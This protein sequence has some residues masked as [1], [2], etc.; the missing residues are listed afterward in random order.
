M[1]NFFSLSVKK[2]TETVREW[3]QKTPLKKQTPVIKILSEKVYK[4]RSA[5]KGFVPPKVF[6]PLLG[7]G[8]VT[9][10]VQTVHEV[11]DKNKNRLGFALRLRD[12]NEVGDAFIGLYHSTCSTFRL[13][14][15]PETA[16]N[17]NDTEATGNR[18][19]LPKFIGVTIHHEESRKCADVTAMHI[20][21]I[22]LKQI[23]EMNG[24]WKCFTEDEIQKRDPRIVRSSLQQ[25]LWVMSSNKKSFQDIRK[26]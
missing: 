5:N 3:S 24:T 22:T 15:T 12:K 13:F 9:F 25:L 7:M 26:F 21:Q 19:D 1:K 4:E 23:N 6:E 14:D 20:R 10:S 16:L 18:E 2:Q 11:V 8:G 17:R